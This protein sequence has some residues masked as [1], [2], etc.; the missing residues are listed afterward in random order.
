MARKTKSALHFVTGADI[1][2]NKGTLGLRD[3]AQPGYVPPVE[4]K[5]PAKKAPAKKADDK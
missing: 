4:D 3:S 2:V 1:E 5:K